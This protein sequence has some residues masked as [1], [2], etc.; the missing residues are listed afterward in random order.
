MHHEHIHIVYVH[1]YQNT[2]F[3]VCECVCTR[4]HSCSC[5]C[6]CVHATTVIHE[7]RVFLTLQS[8]NIAA[9]LSVV[10]RQQ[11]INAPITSSSVLV[12]TGHFLPNTSN[13]QTLI[14]S[15]L[16]PTFRESNP[17][18]EK[19]QSPYEPHTMYYH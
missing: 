18:K 6:A 17:P 14:F 19:V 13:T 5:V 3:F 1:T 11:S 7:T 8:N 15:L 10:H 2:C 16:F 12:W 4:K 9:C